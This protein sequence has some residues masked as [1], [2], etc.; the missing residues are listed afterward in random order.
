M[1]MIL[2]LLEDDA[3]LRR[4]SAQ[5]QKTVVPGNCRHI[6]KRKIAHPYG[7]GLPLHISPFPPSAALHRAVSY[8]Y[9]PVGYND[10]RMK[11]KMVIVNS[12][13]LY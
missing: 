6:P 12:F 2:R 7:R 1:M 5:L 8:Y 4:D 13:T 10:M 3:L 9:L 11:F